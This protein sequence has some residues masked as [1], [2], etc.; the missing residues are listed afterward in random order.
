[1][2][3]YKRFQKIHNMIKIQ[4]NFKN[5]ALF[6]SGGVEST[7]IYYL[8][9][10]QTVV[11]LTLYIIDRYNN[12][13]EK[14]NKVFNEINKKLPNA[15]SILIN[16]DIP[17]LSTYEQIGY[18]YNLIKSEHDIIVYGGNKYPEDETIRPKLKES[19]INFDEIKKDTTIYAPLIDY[20]KSEI[21]KFYY[22]I[23]IF[24]L[25]PITHSCGSNTNIPCRECFNCKER[26]WA[27][28][29]LNLNL[30]LDYGV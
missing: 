27:Y 14:A 11:P 26:E 19:Y 23:G 12:P 7:L 8:F 25:L 18:L 2:L 29:K 13:I 24:D 10:T 3:K 21:I 22:E 1:M 5:P 28:K 20:D 6:F 16:K 17:K 4:N 15:K 9:A 30:D